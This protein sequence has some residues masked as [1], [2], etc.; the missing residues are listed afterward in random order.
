MAGPWRPPARVL[1]CTAVGEPGKTVVR[2]AGWLARGLGAPVTLLH[3]AREAV[4]QGDFIRAHLA[5]G[6]SALRSFEVPAEA[7]IRTSRSPAEGILSEAQE[8]EAGLIAIG[9]HGPRGR[10][11]FGRDDVTMQILAA[12]RTPVLVVPENAW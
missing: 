6:I 10:S 4:E 2:V 7:R 8:R 12:A 1:A 5:R 9:G 3:V 11:I